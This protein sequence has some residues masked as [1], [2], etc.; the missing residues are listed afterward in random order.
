MSEKNSIPKR[1][2]WLG[3]NIC[4]DSPVWVSLRDEQHPNGRWELVLETALSVVDQIDIYGLV[5]MK[6]AMDYWQAHNP[7][8]ISAEDL[9]TWRKFEPAINAILEVE[10]VH[11][12]PVICFERNGNHTSIC[13]EKELTHQLAMRSAQRM[14][15]EQSADGYSVRRW[16]AERASKSSGNNSSARS[17]EVIHG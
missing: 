2:T 16:V 9:Q 1:F 8:Q 10:A 14:C 11:F 6:T 3:D 5:R 4:L 13:G 15:E 12:E 7:E 17:N